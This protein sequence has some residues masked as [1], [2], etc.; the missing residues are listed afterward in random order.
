MAKPVNQRLADEAVKHRLYL[1]RLGTGTARKL[2]AVMKKAEL[3]I[4]MELFRALEKMQPSAMNWNQK[5]LASIKQSLQK[6]TFSLYE[7]VFGQLSDDLKTLVKYEVE[8]QYTALKG[9]FPLEA[10]PLVNIQSTTWQQVWAS[11]TAK[12]FQGSLLKEWAQRAP[13]ALVNKIGNSVQ[14]GILLGESYTDIIKR[15]KGTSAANYADGV[16]GRARNVDLA[17]IVKTAVNHVTAEAREKTVEVNQ[18]IIKAREWLST[19]DSHTSP[20]CIIRDKLKYTAGDK[21]KPIGHTVPYGAGPGRLHFCC[22]S[23][24]TWI[25]KSWQELGIKANEL[26][27]GT[28]ASMNGQVPSDM[29]YGKWLARQDYATQEQVLGVTRAQMLRDGKIDV[30]DLFGDKGEWLTLD[31]LRKLDG[32]TNS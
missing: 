26:S 28:R 2:Q 21:P 30:P 18:D 32:I 31:Q 29:T 11:A 23:T 5:R 12:P 13:E 1:A 10:Q 8:Y 20:M 19:L 24:E 4:S 15:V 14:Q 6:T 7:Q 16:V 27:P 25:I 9:A 22:R 17:N 3:E